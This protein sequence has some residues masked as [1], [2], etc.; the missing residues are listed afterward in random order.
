[1]FGVNWSNPPVSTL[2]DIGE[3]GLI[4]RMTRALPGSHSVLVGIGDDCAVLK[5]GNSLW[6]VSCDASVEGV[7][8][9]RQT[10]PPWDIGWKAAAAALSDIAAMGGVPRFVLVAMALPP[11]TELSFAEELAQGIAAAAEHAGA[12]IVGGDTTRALSELFLDITVIGEPIEGRYLCRKGA[13]PGDTLMV[14]GSLGRSIGGLHALEAGVEA[15]ELIQ[16]HRHPLPRIQEGQWLAAQ[17]A[18]HAMIDLS[19]GL[20]QDTGHLAA[21]GGLGVNIHPERVPV[22]EA[23][24]KYQDR[25]ACNPLLWALTGGEEYELIAA[26]DTAQC[27]ELC[28]TY[29]E[30]FGES[31][32]LIG[33][34][35]GDWQG[36]RVA[37]TVPEGMGFDH[38]RR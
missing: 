33:E 7:H 2:R 15:P 24:R 29:I 22:A 28:A 25:L 6:M 38:F 9:R 30:Q 10:A 14:T 20:L 32:T 1:M 11:E 36:V 34:F 4:A 13:R 8:F 35:T 19:D 3:F 27:A 23:L 5:T 18:V 31:L 26:V 12:I 17:S 21:A 37:G 16:A